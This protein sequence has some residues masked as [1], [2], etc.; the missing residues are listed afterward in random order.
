MSQEIKLK[1][2]YKKS[3]KNTHVYESSDDMA[4]IPSLYIRRSALNMFYDNGEFPESIVVTV[5]SGDK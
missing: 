1:M 2:T 3:T 4:Q 5:T